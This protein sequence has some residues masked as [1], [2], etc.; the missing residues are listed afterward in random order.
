MWF[1][2]SIITLICWSGSDLFSKI[3]CR[4]AKDKNSH[5]KTVVALDVNE[6]LAVTLKKNMPDVDVI[7][8]DIKDSSVKE[9]VIDLAVAR[10]VNMI[11][12]G[13]PC[14]G[15]SLKGKKARQKSVELF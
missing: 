10:G 14:Q 5:F 9:K 3:G 15:Y 12:G 6:K 1:W 4:D 2:L 11:I 7:F 8:G 13:P